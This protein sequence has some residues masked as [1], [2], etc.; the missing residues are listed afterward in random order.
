M[1]AG[2]K[3]RL[4]ALDGIRAYAALAVIVYHAIL[5]VDHGLIQ[6]VLPKTFW[7]VDA[8]DIWVKVWLSTFNGAAAVELFFL[9]SG[10]V[11][12]RSLD[13]A[14]GTW[15]AVSTSFAIKRA[16]RIYPGLIPC[17]AVTAAVT[18]SAF[19]WGDIAGNMALWNFD[20]VGPSWT[21]Q[22][23]ML[24]LPLL[25]IVGLLHR[26]WGAWGI[27]AVLAVAFIARKNHEVFIAP[28]LG[29]FGY[30]FV[31][32]SLAPSRVG[33]VVASLAK[34]VGWVPVVVAFV[35]LRQCVGGMDLETAALGFVLLA[36][37]YHDDRAAT[38]PVLVSRV[39]QF[40]GKLSFGIYLWNVPF[41]YMPYLVPKALLSLDTVTAGLIISAVIIP[42]SIVLATLSHWLIETPGIALGKRLANL[43]DFGSRRLP[44]PEAAS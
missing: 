32:G 24:A 22:V 37:L 4:Q 30:L 1:G 27:L 42:L 12:V 29:Q 39:P 11:L 6:R 36:L 26:K 34:P 25:L 8:S 38:S 20:V 23:E 21:L 17:V 40:L 13:A 33:S 18:P 35:F 44:A 19:S 7:E 9:L 3:Q 2:S 43:A 15:L 5:L 14:K 31:L 28:L 16:L 10:C 41:F